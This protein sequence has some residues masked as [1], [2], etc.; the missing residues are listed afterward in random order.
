MVGPIDVV[1][2]SLIAIGSVVLVGILGYLIEKGTQE[3]N[4]EGKKDK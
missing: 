4:Q 2:V 3:G 1:F